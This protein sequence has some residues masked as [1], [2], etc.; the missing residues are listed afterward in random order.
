MKTLAPPPG[1]VFQ[2]SCGLAFGV[3]GILF[4]G[5]WIGVI[6]FT[7]TASPIGESDP[8]PVI[9]LIVIGL[10]VFVAGLFG[11]LFGIR[12][13][14]AG[15]RAARPEV[16][17]SSDELRVG[18][19][20]TVGFRQAFTRPATVRNVRMELVFHEWA[21]YSAGKNSSTHTHDESISAFS[22]PGGEFEA[23]G[24]LSFTQPMQIPRNG[25]HTFEAAHNKLTW[26][27]RVTVDIAGWVDFR[28]DYPLQVLPAAGRIQ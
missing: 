14:L 3:L 18:D 13:W 23:G 25:M 17:I 16:T 4:A 24:E 6:V 8:V 10:P 11:I 28:E 7:L 19:A 2:R 22:M 12:P 20:I 1:A 9:L 26:F 5:I 27:L 21:Y 15:M